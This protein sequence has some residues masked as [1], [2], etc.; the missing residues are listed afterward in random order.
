MA[1]RRSSSDSTQATPPGKP[2]RKSASGKGES[3]RMRLLRRAGLFSELPAEIRIVRATT[4]EE[5]HDSYSLVHE[6]FLDEGY[7]RP[8]PGGLR[9]RPFEALP[10]TA[11]FIAK[12]GGKIV[13]V[14]S[15]IPD[16]Q[17]LGVPSDRAFRTELDSLR[18]DGKLVC[19]AANETIDT[20]YRKGA[21]PTELMRCCFAHALATG[22]SDLVTAI[23]EGHARFYELMGFERFTPVR[24]FSE[25]LNDPVVLVRL[26]VTA[27]AQRA[28]N[29][30]DDDRNDE[31]LLKNYYLDGNPYHRRVG[32]WSAM[33]ERLFADDDLLRKLFLD[34]SDLLNRCNAGELRAIAR[35]WGQETL[36][37]VAAVVKQEQKPSSRVSRWRSPQPGRPQAHR[38]E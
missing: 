14:Q 29:V 5:L 35:T 18:G 15:L 12:A 26:D 2:P 4:L 9:M 7:I 25:Q 8:F 22:C 27:V 34:Q 23:S 19:E 24:S 17:G 21:V 28:A 10:A 1:C 30:G 16:T 38:A 32:A 33:A 31:A 13:G 37:R 6:V 11:T 3:R 20:D 36:D